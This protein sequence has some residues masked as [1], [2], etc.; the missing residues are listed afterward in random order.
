MASIRRE[1]SK[2]VSIQM[3]SR[4]NKEG[5]L[6]LCVETGISGC[7]VDVTVLVQRAPTRDEADWRGFVRQVFGC[8]DDPTFERAP[9]GEYEHREILA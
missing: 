9:Q 7:E 6:D 4:T 2:M 5:L 3:K 1:I 8:I